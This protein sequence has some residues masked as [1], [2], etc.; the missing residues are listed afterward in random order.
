[1]VA[2]GPEVAALIEDFEDVHQLMGR[3][4]EVLDHDKTA[5]VQNAFTKDVYSLVNVK[6][7]LGNPSEEENKD[8]LVLDGK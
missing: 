7:E 1:M 5:S 4:D 6:G 3:R 8:L 2:A